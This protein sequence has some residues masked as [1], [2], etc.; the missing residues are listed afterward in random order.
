MALLATQCCAIGA[1]ARSMLWQGSTQFLLHTGWVGCSWGTAPWHALALSHAE[2]TTSSVVTPN[3]RLGSY[4]PAAFSTDA[5]IGTVELTGLEMMLSS[6]CARAVSALAAAW[7]VCEH[8]ISSGRSLAGLQAHTVSAGGSLAVRGL[9]GPGGGACGPRVAE[10]GAPAWCQRGLTA[11]SGGS[12]LPS[13]AACMSSN[14][15]QQMGCV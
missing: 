11:V 10:Q 2:R 5:A 14:R 13:H 15:H 8:A 9:R 3:R 6:A 4:T 12:S 7:P 1:L